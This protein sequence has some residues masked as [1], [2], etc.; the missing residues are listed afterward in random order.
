MNK[1]KELIDKMH[2]KEFFHKIYLFLEKIHVISFFKKIAYY[3]DKGIKFILPNSISN[4]NNAYLVFKRMTIFGACF[5]AV[6]FIIVALI[7]FI[8]VKA[9][10]SS[11]VLPNIEGKEMFEAF[12]LLE[13]EGMNFS[14]QSHYFQDYP[15]GTVISQEPKGG[16]KVKRGRTVY[17]VINAIESSSAVMPDIVGKSYNEAVNIISNEVLTKLTN[18]TILTNVETYNSKYRE[19]AVVSQLPYAKETLSASSDIILT[20]NVKPISVSN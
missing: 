4:D 20:I 7:I 14:V 8:V 13:K 3:V 12:N 16:I 18:I 9:G 5:F 10:G 15:L 11:F 6:Q 17:L 1:I 19:N 2:L